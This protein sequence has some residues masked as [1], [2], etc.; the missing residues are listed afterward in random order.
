MHGVVSF[1]TDEKG[2]LG[3]FE[4]QFESIHFP[5]LVDPVL[6]KKG[7]GYSTVQFWVYAPYYAKTDYKTKIFPTYDTWIY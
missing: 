1:G 4:M 6:P 2:I 5:L 7:L 3:F